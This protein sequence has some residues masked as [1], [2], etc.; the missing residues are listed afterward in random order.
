MRNEQN[1]YV[2]K[3]SVRSVAELQLPLAIFGTAF[4]PEQVGLRPQSI[5]TLTTR[6]A[7]SCE[8]SN[9]GEECSKH[10]PNVAGE[11]ATDPRPEVATYP[12]PKAPQQIHPRR[13]GEEG[14]PGNRNRR[15][16][17]QAPTDSESNPGA[18]RTGPQ[19][20]E[21]RTAAAGPSE[22]RLLD[23]VEPDSAVLLNGGA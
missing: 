20:S 18:A 10:L 7:Q 2:G 21:D 1:V 6:D 8:D 12:R 4:H 9:K 19:R 14:Q 16:V 17:A 15:V 5:T 11:V 3:R 22:A 23:Q 13:L